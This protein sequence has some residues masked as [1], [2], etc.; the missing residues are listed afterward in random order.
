M[1][2][3]HSM[4]LLHHLHLSEPIQSFTVALI[5]SQ[6]RAFPTTKLLKL[7]PQPQ[8]IISYYQYC[9]THRLLCVK[10]KHVEME[11]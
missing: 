1:L 3:G 10:L 9:T 6:L 4:R 5:V 2:A 11:S 8:F 7:K